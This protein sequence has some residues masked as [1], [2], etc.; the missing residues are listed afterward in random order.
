MNTKLRGEKMKIIKIIS[1]ARQNGL[2]F[3]LFKMS[4]WVSS[5]CKMD[6]FISQLG[7][8]NLSNLPSK[9]A[10]A[11]PGN[12]SV[13]FTGGLL[14][15][16]II[17]TLLDNCRKSLILFKIWLFFVVHR[18]LHNIYC[19]NSLI[20][21]ELRLY[22][23]VNF[24]DIFVKYTLR[25]ALLLTLYFASIIPLS[26]S[27]LVAPLYSYS[28]S[29][30]YAEPTT[31]TGIDLNRIIQIESSGNPLAYNKKSRC[32][33]LCQISEITLKEWNNFHPHQK[34]TSQDLFN[35]N[36]NIKI[37]DWYLGQRIPQMLRYYHK[38]ITI[39]NLIIAYNAGIAY[40]RHGWDIPAETKDYLRKYNRR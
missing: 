12:K 13:C 5:Q 17:H 36:V 3:L 22:S 14:L 27:L 30:V 26:S 28:T 40:V 8:Y 10:T 15:I 29:I 11:N 9:L 23:S 37:A 7:R 31:R 18:S 24:F 21:K 19:S 38:P 20:L 6:I 1:Q 39:T 4:S 32:R 33:G 25:S 35:P 16:G 34:Y 2:G